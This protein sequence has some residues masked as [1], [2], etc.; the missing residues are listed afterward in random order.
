MLW[1]IY[2]VLILILL[3]ITVVGCWRLHEPEA[4]ET[5]TVSLEELSDI[6][7][8]YNKDVD[9]SEEGQ[10]L[11]ALYSEK[12]NGED[13]GDGEDEKSPPPAPPD[14]YKKTLSPFDMAAPAAFIEDCIKPYQDDFAAQGVMPLAEAVIDLLEKH[15]ECP[16]IVLDSRDPESVELY[17]VRNNLAKTTLKEHTYT[18]ARAVIETVKNTYIDHENHVPKAVITALAHDIGKIPEFRASGAYNTYT[19][20]QIS[21]SKLKELAAGIRVPWLDGAVL[22]IRDHHIRSTDQFTNILK[23]ADRRAR[24]ME[25]LASVK[26]LT[27]KPF[28]QWFDPQKLVNLIEPHVNRLISGEKWKA[29]SYKGIVYCLP[30]FLYEKTK[31]LCRKLKVLDL[32]FIYESE[33]ETAL[34]QVAR[35]LREKGYVPDLL[36]PHHY[37]GRFEIRSVAGKKRFLLTPFRGEFFNLQEIEARKVGYLSM[38][39]DVCYV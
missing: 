26:D 2:A 28:D 19:H 22:A 14:E 5:I 34:R 7:L 24:E 10:E 39:W 21:V 36:Q 6:W 30:D 33:K 23:Q 11:V 37:S 38:I 31:E 18:V 32:M 16:S 9:P 27:I 20:P 29:F 25:L 15:G 1:I 8:K 13:E 17:S 3:I 4:R 35:S 12:S